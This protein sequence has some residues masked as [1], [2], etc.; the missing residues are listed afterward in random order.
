MGYV[1]VL[2]VTEFVGL[3]LIWQGY[4]MSVSNPQPAPA[5]PHEGSSRGF[6]TGVPHEG[7]TRGFPTGVPHGGATR[8]K[9]TA[10][11]S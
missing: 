11:P 10:E 5:V 3:L 2:Y 6:L 9:E 1:E 7:A 4:R 8:K